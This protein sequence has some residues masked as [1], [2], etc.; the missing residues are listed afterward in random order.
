MLSEGW[1]LSRYR[2]LQVVLGNTAELTCHQVE[3]VRELEHIRQVHSQRRKQRDEERSNLKKFESSIEK[4]DVERADLEQKLALQQT[5]AR[6]SLQ[7]SVMEENRALADAK[8]EQ[9]RQERAR[10]VTEDLAN[11]ELFNERWGSTPR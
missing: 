4:M 10:E 1:T 7:S 11:L 6:R 5:E 9:L 2:F 8:R 3:R